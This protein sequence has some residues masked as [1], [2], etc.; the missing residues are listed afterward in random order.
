[1]NMEQ[2]K[3]SRIFDNSDFGFWSITVERP[4]RL[5]V[6]PERT[7]PADTFKNA[8]EFERCLKQLIVLKYMLIQIRV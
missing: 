2:S 1:M 3:V 8:D 5:R 7:I 4:L 6:Y